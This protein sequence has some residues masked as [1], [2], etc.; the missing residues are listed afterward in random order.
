MDSTADNGGRK[1]K[2]SFLNILANLS[3]PIVIKLRDFL[4]NLIPL[5]I[6]YS[7]HL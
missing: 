4:P 5:I 3:Q 7:K 1:W 6:Q 2:T